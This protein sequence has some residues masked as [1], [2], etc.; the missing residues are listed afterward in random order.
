MGKVSD[1]VAALNA[2]SRATSSVVFSGHGA[3]SS[4]DGEFTV[5]AGTTVTFYQP[6]N[7][8][9]RNRTGQLVDSLTRYSS[10]A[11]G[12]ET[13]KGGQKCKNY[14]LYPRERLALM[15]H[16]KFEQRFITTKQAQGVQ[17]KDLVAQNIGKDCHW[18]AC[19]NHI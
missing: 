1:R 13:F 5:P 14:R 17:L 3:W 16:S 9:L 7:A 8:S 15:G 6:D 4:A 18:A 2:E 19:R 12:V 11:A 10:G